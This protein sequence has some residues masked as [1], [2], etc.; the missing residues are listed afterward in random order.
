[1][2]KWAGEL[3]LEH[4]ELP[5][6]LDHHRLTVIAE[7]GKG[8]IP[9]ERMG[10]GENWVGYHLIT[11][12]ALHKWFVGQHRPVPRFIFIDQPSQVYFPEDES[13]QQKT[14]ENRNIGEDRK[15]V[16]R[17]YKLADDV[18]NALEGEFQIIITDH[19]NIDQTW[20]QECVRERWREGRKLI[21]DEWDVPTA[22][23][24]AQE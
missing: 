11:H 4:A 8:V 14:G 19:A 5:L 10:S 7:D 21:P 22:E 13:W 6:R 2:N 17:M 18:V 9:M 12:F 15:K 24:P 20:F 3:Q 23:S 1:M 16:E